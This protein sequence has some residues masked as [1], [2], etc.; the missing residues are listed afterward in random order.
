M[1]TATADLDV[2]TSTNPAALG[3]EALKRVNARQYGAARP[4][5]ERALSLE[6]H[7]A[8]LAHVKGH[9]TQDSGALEEGAAYL[10]AF[11]T[12]HDPHQG[13]NVHTAWHLAMHELE[14]ARPAAALDW[15]V[16]VVAPKVPQFPMTFFSAVALLWR[17][18]LYGYGAALRARGEQLPWE[19]ARDAA[20]GLDDPSGL[21]DTACAMAFLATGN[22]P[23]LATLLERLRGAGAISSPAHAEVVLSL[24]EGFRAFWRGDYAAAVDAIEP[25][26]PS[27]GCITNVP[28]QLAVFED[29]MVEAQL[30]AGRF[31]AAE[32]A[33]RR[34]LAIVDLPRYR[35][36]LGRAQL[37]LGQ[38]AE[39]AANLRAAREGW[40]GAEPDA[41]E[42]AALAS[43]PL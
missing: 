8:I 40:C 33:L 25:V 43:L 41:P 10:R 2:T 35:Y 17:L 27:S 6:P 4:M 9:L 18:E 22:E 42:L 38:P 1:Q 26:V 14:L 36:W 16:R 28:D 20:L 29:T 19:E 32:T 23:N 7:N 13:I 31:A 12:E 24:V 11:L 37:G 5:I 15:H 3:Q 21:D 39:A 30:R 34:R